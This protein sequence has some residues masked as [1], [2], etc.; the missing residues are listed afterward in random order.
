MKSTFNAH[1]KDKIEVKIG[2]SMGVENYEKKKKKNFKKRNFRKILSRK[3]SISLSP[4]TRNVKYHGSNELVIRT[5][6]EYTRLV[7]ELI[8]LSQSSYD[9]I[10]L[11]NEIR[12]CVTS[13]QSDYYHLRTFQLSI[14]EVISHSLTESLFIYLFLLI[15]LFRMQLFL[16][17][18][19]FYNLE[20]V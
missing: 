1:S 6:P 8:K 7:V 14:L 10:E 11:R 20:E 15:H 13:L 2:I 9:K 4:S 18:K 16:T 12:K 5:A 3:M 19:R 17:C